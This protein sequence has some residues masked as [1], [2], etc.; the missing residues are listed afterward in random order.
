HTGEWPYECGQYGN[1]FSSG[2]AFVNHQQIHT[3]L[4]PFC[5]PNC[6]KG[7]NRN[8]KLVIHVRIHTGETQRVR[9]L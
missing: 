4:K 1:D 8:S 7:F 2:S 5:C 9:P 3:K 6:G